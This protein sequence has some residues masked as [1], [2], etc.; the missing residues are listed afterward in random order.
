MKT[1]ATLL[2]GALALAAAPTVLGQGSPSKKHFV[3]TDLMTGYQETVS[4]PTA[5][6]TPPAGPGTISSTGT[7]EFRAEIDDEMETITYTLTYSGLE[8]GA[9]LFAHI[10]FGARG[11]TGG[12]SAFLCGGGT[13]PTPCPPGVLEPATVTGTVTPADVVG[14]TGQGIEP[15]TGFPELVRAMRSGVTYVNVHTTRWPAGEIRGQIADHNER[16]VK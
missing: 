9:V 10:H 7:G 13:K 12:V 8:G 3:K 5:P 1:S 2:L 6:A 16:Q 11:T 15:I 4:A 14:P